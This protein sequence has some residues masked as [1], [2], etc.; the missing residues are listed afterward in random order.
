ME[1]TASKNSIKGYS[2]VRLI[3]Q[4]YGQF[5]ESLEREKEKLHWKKEEK[6]ESNSD[7]SVTGINLT[8]KKKKKKPDQNWD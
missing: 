5:W 4:E 8:V 6:T 3:I 7:I 2:A 1:Q